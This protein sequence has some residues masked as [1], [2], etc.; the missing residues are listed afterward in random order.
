MALLKAVDRYDWRGFSSSRPTRR[1]WIP[2]TNQPSL[3]DTGKTIRLPVHIYEDAAHRSRRQNLRFK[4]ATPRRWRGDTGR[5][6]P[7]EARGHLAHGHPPL[8][9]HENAITFDDLV[10]SSRK[11]SSLRAIRLNRQGNSSARIGGP[12]FK[13]ALNA[14]SACSRI[15]SRRRQTLEGPL[16]LEIGTRI[17]VTRQ[18][19]P[20]VEAI[21]RSGPLRHPARADRLSRVRSGLIRT[22]S[23][24]L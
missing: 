5:T 16:T 2:P 14:K 1:G 19:D 11:D 20:E 17:D 23:A 24:E 10:A 12:I 15:C 13:S 22:G 4:P 3:A 18:S 7:K 8:T 9:L 21:T 6:P